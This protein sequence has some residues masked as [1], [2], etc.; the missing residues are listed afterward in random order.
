MSVPKWLQAR[1][2]S[3]Q[4]EKPSTAPAEPMV[5][6]TPVVANAVAN[7]LPMVANTAVANRHGKYAD[8]DRRRTYMRDLMRRRRAAAMASK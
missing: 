7:N 8:K 3:M 6:N 5:A 2:D 4:R 1:F